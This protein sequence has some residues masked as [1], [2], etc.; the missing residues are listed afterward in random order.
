MDD[1]KL[2]REAEIRYLWHSAKCVQQLLPKRL[3]RERCQTRRFDRKEPKVEI[4]NIIVEQIS[5]G[6]QQ[7]FGCQG[8]APAY[9]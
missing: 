8:G 5:T 6:M 2:T 3:A 1:R 7:V 9:S 4:V